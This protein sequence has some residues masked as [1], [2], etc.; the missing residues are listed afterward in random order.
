MGVSI[1]ARGV[2]VL[3]RGCGA[4]QITPDQNPIRASRW[5]AITGNLRLLCRYLEDTASDSA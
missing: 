1:P 2:P 5:R 3:S 4:A